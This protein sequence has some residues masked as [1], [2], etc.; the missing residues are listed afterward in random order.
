MS[1]E[2]ITNLRL[3]FPGGH[4]L[5]HGKA[6]LMELIAETGSI[7]AAAARMNMSYRRAW[8]LV[9]EMNS[10]F[11]E[12]VVATRHG[13][14]KGGGAF[15]TEF[16]SALLARFRAMEKASAE[17]IAADLAWLNERIVSTAPS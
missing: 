15:L 6:E 17:A 11:G 16:G 14:A 4:R 1:K 8:L 2:V 9:D 10:M 7:R 3:T 5:A 12:A 13:G